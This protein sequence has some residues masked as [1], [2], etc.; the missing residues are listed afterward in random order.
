MK[1]EDCANYGIHEDQGIEENRQ[2]IIVP[3]IN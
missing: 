1:I 3:D 2:V